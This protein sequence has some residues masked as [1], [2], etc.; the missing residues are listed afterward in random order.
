MTTATPSPAFLLTCLALV[1]GE[2]QDSGGDALALLRSAVVA[3]GPSE[4]DQHLLTDV[5]L[6]AH[7]LLVGYDATPGLLHLYGP[8]RVSASTS[9]A[10]DLLSAAD[11]PPHT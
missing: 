5:V 2:V 9:L 8:A 6:V 11:G 1:I 3:V 10:L 4:E 7:G